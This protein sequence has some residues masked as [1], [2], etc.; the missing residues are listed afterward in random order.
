[1]KPSEKTRALALRQ[2]GLTYREIQEQVPVSAST[3]SAW[4][5]DVTLT[6]AQQTRIHGINL[7]VRHRF[8]E[9]NHRKRNAAIA[10]HKS[11]RETAKAEAGIISSELL[12][13][14]GVALYWGEGTKLGS[15]NKL[16]FSNSDPS[17]IQLFMR[18][19]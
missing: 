19:F 5:R 13:W 14:I 7:Q 17:M 16:R 3:L 2:Q 15:K 12:K 18:W 11:W 10:R 8:I 6:E 4:L 1:M 9:Y